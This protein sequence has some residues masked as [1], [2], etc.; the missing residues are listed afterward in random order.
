MADLNPVRPVVIPGDLVH[1]Q[2]RK[3][4]V[5]DVTG[6]GY[7]GLRDPADVEL[8]NPL[9][10]PVGDVEVVGHLDHL[11]GWVEESPGV[12]RQT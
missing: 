9:A 2:G 7:A 8:L 12:W 3:L 6:D 1:Y 5:V 11:D 4:V 10:A